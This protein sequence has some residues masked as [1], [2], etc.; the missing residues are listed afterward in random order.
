MDTVAGRGEALGGDAAEFV[1]LQA[2]EQIR[3]ETAAGAVAGG[4]VD[5]EAGAGE[6]AGDGKAGG[7]AD[8]GRCFDHDPAG[9]G[10]ADALDAIVQLEVAAGE[11]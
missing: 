7:G 5:G 3:I 9:G 2:I 10:E 8:A 4:I 11:G 6:G 1:C